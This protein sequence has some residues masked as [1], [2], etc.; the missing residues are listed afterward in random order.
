MSGIRLLRSAR[1]TVA[2]RV[3]H[4]GNI[5]LVVD[6]LPRSLGGG[7]RIV[8]KMA[9]LLP[10]YGYHATIL[11]FAADEESEGLVNPPCPIYLLPLR[12]TY[13]LAALRGVISLRRFLKEK[14]IDLV[15]TCF[16]SSDLW[17]G[18]VTK[19]FSN[20]KLVW[21]RRD[22]GILRSH[23]HMVAYKK[24]ARMPDA[25]FAVSEQV[26]R[27]CIDVDDIAPDRVSTVHN[28]LDL[29]RWPE[30]VN[31]GQS[32]PPVIAS[33]GNIRRVKGHD[34][35][36][37]AFAL[38]RYE[39]PSVRLA[40]GG[41][42]LETAFMEELTSLI[43]ELELAESVSFEGNV[44]DQQRF[45]QDV[46]IFVLP[47][48]SEGFSNAIVE[49]MAASLPVIATDV[50][51][52]AEAVKDGDTGL[53]IRSEDVDGMATAIL[54]LLRDPGEAR[55]MGRAGRKRV[56]EEFTIAAMMQRVVTTFDRLLAIS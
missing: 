52:N 45:L 3:P 53:I 34:V 37:R 25:V 29:A 13:D 7:E 47:S 1:P 27:H 40:L 42:V 4:K 6:Q 20:A 24:L 15:H 11:T 23:K 21:N 17:A 41:A 5:L 46:S 18:G 8:R 30:R 26:R 33:L 12:R 43:D 35:L 9:E 10:T 44:Q 51:G 50:G 28:G 14:G 16:E 55:Q 54:R 48:R 31:R 38:V 32:T 19:L 39:F 36:L 49:A 56:V 22:M 2:L